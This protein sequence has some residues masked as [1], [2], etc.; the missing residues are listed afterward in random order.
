MPAFLSRKGTNLKTFFT[1]CG[2]ARYA[3]VMILAAAAAIAASTPQPAAHAGV[4]VSAQATVTI[5]VISGVQLSF[6]SEQNSSGIPRA[7][8]T[9]INTS[10]GQQQP[11]RLIEFQ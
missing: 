6:G 11:A 8:N 1:I 2:G 7:R 3:P 4:G 5:R 9:L 10:D